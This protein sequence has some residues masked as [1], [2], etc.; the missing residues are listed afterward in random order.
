[1]AKKLMIVSLDLMLA[2]PIVTAG[3][4]FLFSSIAS[5]QPYLA[6][7][8]VSQNITLSMLSVSQRISAA[9]GLEGLN[10]S[11]AEGLASSLAYAG[12]V[13]Y[14]I[15]KDPVGCGMPS[16]L[17]RVITISGSAYVL[18]LSHASAN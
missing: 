13:S 15:Q 3:F 7:L 5:S 4:A 17:C 11:E 2:L 12:G 9:I 10:Y 18:V 16:T 1:M 14:R 6:D 8:A